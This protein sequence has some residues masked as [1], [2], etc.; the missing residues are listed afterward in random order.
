MATSS[1]NAGRR[2]AIELAN[3]PPSSILAPLQSPSHLHAYNHD[4]MVPIANH[5]SSSSSSSSSSPL[6]TWEHRITDSS[7]PPHCILP[8]RMRAERLTRGLD[9]VTNLRR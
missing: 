8:Y 6:P 2:R 4:P 7:L 5:P 9:S 3:R 1:S